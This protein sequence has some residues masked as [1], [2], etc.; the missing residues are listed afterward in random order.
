MKAKFRKLGIVGLSA[1]ALASCGSTESERKYVNVDNGDVKVEVGGEK[2]SYKGASASEKEKILGLLEE[3]AVN[4][5]LTGIS[6]FEDGGYQM[7]SPTV[8]LGTDTYITGYG[9]GTLKEGNITAD[10]AG[11]SNST[12][13]RY[14]HTSTS[15]DPGNVNYMDDKTSTVGD[16]IEYANAAYFTT[17]MNQTKDGY[18]WVG[19]LSKQ[20]RPEAVNAS[21]DGTA[22]TFRFEVKVGS[23]LKYNTLTSN[24]ELKKYAGREV[25]LEDYLTPFKILWNKKIG[26]ARAAEN[27]TASVGIA[28]S[29][30]YYNCTDDGI[31]EVAFED[32]GLKVYQ[33]NGKNYFEFT[34][35]EATT[36]FMAMY[37]INS[38]MY[39]P[40]PMDFIKDLGNGDLYDGAKAW[41]KKTDSGLTPVD[42][43]LATG[44]YV[45]ENWE[46][47]K[48]IVWTKNTMV[49]TSDFYKIQGIHIAVLKALATDSEAALNEFLADKLSSCVIPQTQLSK[50]KTDPRTKQFTGSSVFK[51]NVNSC[52]EE[53]WEAL[54]GENGTICQTNKSDYWQVEPAM[55]ND[56]FLLGLSYSINRTEFADNRGSV[57]SVNYFSSN[58]L[59][60]PEN[61][62]SYNSTSAHQNAIA[63]R[64]SQ[65]NLSDGYSLSLAQNY[66]YKG[67]QELV[68]Q[69]K[70]KSG[71]TIEIEIAWMYQ[72]HITLY[73]EDIA[74]YFETAF[75]SSKAKTEL[76]LTLKVTN[77]AVA[78]WSDVYYSKMMVG[79]YDLAFGSISGNAYDP[80]N[81]ME[82]LKSDNSSG[83]TL[84]WGTDTN[85]PGISYDGKTWSFD[86]LWQAT[87]TY[88]YV[89]SK[90]ARTES[91]E[92]VQAVLKTSKHN[93]DNSRTVV[94]KTACAYETD[95]LIED[96][97]VFYG[98]VG[99][100]KIKLDSSNFEISIDDDIII[101]KVLS[102]V[103]LV[104]DS[105]D[106]N[107][108]FES[109]SIEITKTVTV[110][111]IE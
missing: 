32:V 76:G 23:E 104:F 29:Y 71:D 54:F 56:Y 39:A 2:V 6:L 48:Q 100:N 77:M 99:D 58:Y 42:T 68:S 110:N 43:T 102:Q 10:L 64:T 88:C 26:Y 79:Q 101:I 72:K 34:L 82:V 90:G 45:L 106:I 8:T 46:T 74:N 52:D 17:Q 62:I 25:Q 41:G 70:Y 75:N 96:G 83:F 9:F 47:D 81:F 36:P 97:F 18:E 63:S 40:V 38:Y 111:I 27:L 55:S 87:D 59:I 1:L 57:P 16:F 61:G 49:D 109:D 12:W 13:K 95:S 30:D 31:D 4:N 15:T 50:Y 11:E 86:A 20:N 7:F 85:M 3:Y 94:I 67:A 98:Y 84:N 21:T 69:G 35:N 103:E 73:G 14:Y 19:D 89:T 65:G 66:F 33:E 93:D 24:S 107:V 53:T 28:G 22:T 60:D 37:Y 78:T 80:L 44:A 91:S 51:L 105:I 108:L 5:N 92:N